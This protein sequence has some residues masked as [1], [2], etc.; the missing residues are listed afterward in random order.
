MAD[1]VKIVVTQEKT[2]YVASIEG[3]PEKKYPAADMKEAIGGLVLIFHND[4]NI[5]ISSTP[6]TKQNEK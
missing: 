2:C 5:E 4:F 1:K 3:Q 6:T